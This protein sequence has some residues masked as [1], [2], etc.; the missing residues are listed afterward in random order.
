MKN[1]YWGKFWEQI[2]Q[3]KGRTTRR[4]GWCGEGRSTVTSATLHDGQSQGKR[5]RSKW[6]LPDLGW[7][8]GPSLLG[9]NDIFCWLYV[10]FS[11]LS[12]SSSLNFLL[13]SSRLGD[14]T[15]RSGDGC[16]ELP[17]VMLDSDWLDVSAVVG[18]V[19]GVFVLLPAACFWKRIQI[20][21]RVAWKPC[22]L[23]HTQSLFHNSLLISSTSNVKQ[24]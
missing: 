1:T 16:R 12:C 9:P 19:A 8:L 2:Y 6:G 14:L 21:S 13:L 24:N 17:S 7:L 20:Y 10:F 22:I 3:G 15:R 5:R 4:T 18:A 11:C 23:I